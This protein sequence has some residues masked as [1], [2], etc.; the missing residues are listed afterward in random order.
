MSNTGTTDTQQYLEY[1]TEVTL[2]LSCP[3]NY[4][5]NVECSSSAEGENIGENITYEMGTDNTLYF[6]YPIM[7]QFI[8]ISPSN[9]N[10]DLVATVC[11]FDPTILNNNS[12][13]SSSGTFSY[14]SLDNFSTLQWMLLIGPGPINIIDSTGPMNTS[15]P[16]FNSQVLG[17]YNPQLMIDG[18]CNVNI[19]LPNTASI[20]TSS[21]QFGIG[22]GLL[23]ASGV[24]INY[25]VYTSLGTLLYSGSGGQYLMST[26]SQ[27]QRA[28][29]KALQLCPLGSGSYENI[30]LTWNL[31]ASESQDQNYQPFSSS[32]NN[33]YNTGA[34]NDVSLNGNLWYYS[35][36]ECGT[37]AI[38]I[39]QP[40]QCCCIWYYQFFEEENI[41]CIMNCGAIITEDVNGSCSA[42]GEY[43]YPLLAGE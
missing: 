17:D 32:Q 25:N 3:S 35:W 2:T 24:P 33:N 40:V 1:T 15:L 23:V 39:I 4:V 11:N 42:V 29:Q 37:S 26:F 34:C 5:A 21:N 6:Y 30:G 36:G 19:Y 38:Q 12:S 9:E 14:A 28:Y 18:D 41:Q 20:I 16:D 10:G 22:L 31:M 43:Q 7:M 13:Y 8:P 27:G